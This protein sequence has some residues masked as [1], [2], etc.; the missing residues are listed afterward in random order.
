MSA[1]GD[2][3]ECQRSTTC[4]CAVG[5]QRKARVRCCGVLQKSKASPLMSRCS[6]ESAAAASVNEHSSHRAGSA[7]IRDVS[8]GR[9]L[10]DQSCTHCICARRFHPD[11]TKT[12]TSQ[13]NQQLDLAGGC[14][15]VI[16]QDFVVRGRVRSPPPLPIL[17]LENTRVLAVGC[18]P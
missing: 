10:A 11:P 5:F 9:N 6:A 7:S 13:Q 3:H 18:A 1:I 8:V 12:R 14:N 16:P 15:A 17:L 2:I 4:Q